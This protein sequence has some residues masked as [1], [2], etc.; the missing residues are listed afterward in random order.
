[1]AQNIF[2]EMQ[3]EFEEGQS[4]IINEERI[5]DEK[6]NILISKSGPIEGQE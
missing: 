3:K 6:T 4:L 2:S 5:D 1:M